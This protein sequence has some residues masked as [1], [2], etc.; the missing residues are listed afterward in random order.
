MKYTGVDIYST[1]RI[2]LKVF[3]DKQHRVYLQILTMQLI[4]WKVKLFF[5][6]FR[7]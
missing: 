6:L 2:W 5:S 4:F 1:M 7:T 3:T